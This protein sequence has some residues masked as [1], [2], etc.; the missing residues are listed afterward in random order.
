[1]R[2]EL[3]NQYYRGRLSGKVVLNGPGKWVVES[4]VNY[5]RYVGLGTGFDQDAI[6]WNAALAHKFLK[7]EALELRVMAYDLLKR[8][9]SVSREVSETYLQSTATNMLQQ[10][11]LFSLTYVLRGFKSAASSE[12]GSGAPPGGSWPPPGD[13]GP[14]PR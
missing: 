4:E 11:F 2:G 6:V 1:M 7:S 3:D 9:V 13:H 10:Y 8:N 12:P 14:G 5:D